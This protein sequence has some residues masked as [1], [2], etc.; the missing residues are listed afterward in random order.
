MRAGFPHRHRCH[1]CTHSRH[2]YRPSPKESKQLSVASW[3]VLHSVSGQGSPAWKEQL[4]PLQMSAPLQ[5]MP[6]SHGLLLFGCAQAPA[7]SQVSLVH[8]FPSSV[9]AVPEG[10]KAAVRCLLAGVALRLGAGASR[11]DGT[12]PAAAGVGTVTVEAVVT[13]CGVIRMRA[14]SR[15]VT[16]V[17]GAHIP[18]IGTDR[19][20]RIKAAVRCLLAG[21]ALRLRTGAS[22]VD[23]TGPAAAG[24]GS[25]TVEAVITGCGVIRMRAASRTVTGVI[26]A[27]IAVIGTGRARQYQSSCPLPPGRCC[28]PSPGQ[29]LPVWTEQLPPLQVSVPLQ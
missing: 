23:G 8:T 2:R 26:G 16:G 13:G 15:T 11:M 3:Q 9:Q 24:V 14:A 10:V 29:G 21:A 7:P 28:T 19:A 4:P 12:G 27:H 18:V 22:R 25:V 20:R 17:I 6:S 1:R 5:K